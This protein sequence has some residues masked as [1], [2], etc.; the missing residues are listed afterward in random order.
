MLL[1]V[2]KQ[3]NAS[4]RA[5]TTGPR[6]A[7]WSCNAAATVF[8]RG[9]ELRPGLIADVRAKHR[10]CPCDQGLSPISQAVESPRG[11]R[12]RADRDRHR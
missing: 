9:L 2:A 5:T 10:R 8:G 3:T 1:A 6:S 4:R 11:H 12:L 7:T